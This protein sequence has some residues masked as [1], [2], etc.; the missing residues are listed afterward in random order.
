M[1]SLP[2]DGT[3]A[4]AN[5]IDPLARS[6]IVNLNASGDVNGV[7]G[8][9]RGIM[10]RA[11]AKVATE[12]NSTHDFSRALPPELQEA[13]FGPLRLADKSRLLLVCSQWRGSIVHLPGMW[14]NLDLCKW[15]PSLDALLA[16]SGRLSLEVAVNSR[17]TSALWGTLRPHG[18]RITRL[19]LAVYDT[20]ALSDPLLCFSLPNPE[21]LTLRS[22][23]FRGPALPTHFLDW[24]PPPCLHTLRLVGM[25]F[26]RYCSAFSRVTTLTIENCM[27][28]LIS[29]FEVIPGLERLEIVA[30][31]YT[32]SVPMLPVHSPLRVMRVTGIGVHDVVSQGYGR[33]ADELTV[34]NVGPVGPIFDAANEFDFPSAL[35]IGAGCV[36]IALVLRR[37][38]RGPTLRFAAQPFSHALPRLFHAFGSTLRM[39]QQ[40]TL[41]ASLR[42]AALARAQIMLPQPSEEAYLPSLRTLCIECAG[43]RDPADVVPLPEKFL[44][45][46]IH[47]PAL[48]GI[49]VVPA[50]NALDYSA[51]ERIDA[52]HLASFIE[53]RLVV[54]DR[55]ALEVSVDN[56]HSTAM[57]SNCADALLGAKVG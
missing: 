27:G 39:I 2:S 16:R 4:L 22:P 14:T 32:M 9:L 1:A 19:D 49:R 57:C 15:T 6:S 36:E 17:S 53:E 40:L 24:H 48:T 33:V 29:V 10:A 43:L 55:G 8:E 11:L 7:F 44:L 34:S 28:S 51:I 41:P 47:A 23:S 30:N 45:G 21:E 12:W 42:K 31:M 54:D 26:P 38:D 5:L 13:C 56:K 35:Y 20:E 50:P 46:R 37:G 52:A 18:S 25:R 3:H